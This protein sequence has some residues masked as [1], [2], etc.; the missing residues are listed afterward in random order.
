VAFVIVVSGAEEIL[1]PQASGPDTLVQIRIYT[2]TN[3]TMPAQ[4]PPDQR[5]ELAEFVRAQRERLKPAALG[6]AA[7]ARRRTPG[8]R[9]E[10]V[11]QLAGVG[12]TWY[13][14]LEQGRDVRA[15]LDVLEAIARALRLTQAERTYLFALAGK[16]DPDADQAESEVVPS[17][18][19]GCVETIG[20][21][22]YIL[23]RGWTAR[24]WNRK[25]AQL[26]AG[27]LDG[28]HGRNLLRY[29]FLNPA[30]RPLIRDY[31]A[32]ARRVVAEFRADVSTHLG[33]PA[34]RTLVDDLRRQSRDFARF[35]E[36]HGVLGR[37]GG[38]RTFNHPRDG[39]LRFEQVTFN[40]ASQPDLKLTILVPAPAG[41]AGR[42]SREASSSKR[43]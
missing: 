28:A 18:L 13:T 25:A 9:R 32:R 6:L 27:W 33:E 35:W 12:T 22:A 17:A 8:L 38:E 11:A 34:I 21:P 7:P 3:S 40:L 19:L 37:E 41:R 1:S 20:A 36:E 39:L 5:R 10:E 30:A 26:F 29:I 43:M 24:A 31:E 4:H 23:D 16:R 42:K 2:G 14:W 15:S